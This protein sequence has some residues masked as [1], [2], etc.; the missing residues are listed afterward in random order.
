[1]KKI[2]AVLVVCGSLAGLCLYG[3]ATRGSSGDALPDPVAQTE[4]EDTSSA[5]VVE[6][7]ASEESESERSEELEGTEVGDVV[8]VDEAQ[9][10]KNSESE[11]NAESLDVDELLTTYVVEFEDLDGYKIRE[12]LRVSPIF[13]EDD[14]ET[15]RAL[16]V[17]LGNDSSTF[18]N[19]GSF[20]EIGEHDMLEYV[21]GTY[22]LENMTD[23]FPIT[24]DNPRNYIGRII[25]EEDPSVP[26]LYIVNTYDYF[27][28][29]IETIVVYSNRIVYYGGSHTDPLISNAKMEYDVWG[30]Q[31]FIIAL[32]NISTPNLPD[33]Y[34][35]DTLQYRL[36]GNDHAKG[37]EYTVFKLEYYTK[38]VE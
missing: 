37:E 27:Q 35:Y 34:R 8:F 22:M 3:V 11:C 26:R 32:P 10:N 7:A 21:I 18:P 31:P 13:T 15:M 23:G 14:T 9:K 33:G 2:V 36:I 4:T 29:A 38:E 28:F 19:E 25:P 16:W 30:P 17:A 5:E 1:M 12:T 20:Y 24:P 6:E